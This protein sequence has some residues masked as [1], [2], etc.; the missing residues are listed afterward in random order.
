MIPALKIYK[1]QFV[2]DKAVTLRRYS[3]LPLGVDIIAGFV[4]ACRARRRHR[5]L[6]AVA[7]E[8]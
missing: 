1:P 7:I 8:K 2:I 5:M 6:S 3:L 4:K